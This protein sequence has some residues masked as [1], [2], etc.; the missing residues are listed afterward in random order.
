M[1]VSHNNTQSGW[2]AWG[3]AAIGVALVIWLG[4][5]MVTLLQANTSLQASVGYLTE[6]VIELKLQMSAVPILADRVTGLEQRQADDMRRIGSLEHEPQ[7]GA[8]RPFRR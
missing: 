5:S 1:T 6:T 2:L 3:A 8:L 7:P 4:A